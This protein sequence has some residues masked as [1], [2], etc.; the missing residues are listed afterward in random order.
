VNAQPPAQSTT[1]QH[2]FVIVLENESYI[3]TF[4]DP[5]LAP[6]LAD[7]LP[8]MGALLRQYYGVGHN[9]LD[10]YIAMI[11]GQAP[12]PFTQADC[13][14]YK[15]F[16]LKQ[17]QLD[18]NG[19][20]VGVGCVYPR[21]V[22]TIADQLDA[23]EHSKDSGATDTSANSRRIVWK[24]YMQDLG[25][26]PRREG[27]AC[28]HPALDAPDNTMRGEPGDH[29][30]TK[31]NPFFYFHSI[32]DAPARCAAHVVNLRQ[33]VAD[34]ASASSTPAFSFITPNLCDD[35]H[36]PSCPG[37]A[38]TSG[39]LPRADRFLRQW[40]PIITASAAF[41]ENGLL[42]I[43][44]DESG[45]AD[46][47]GCCVEGP[48]SDVPPAG[49]GRVGA[50]VLSPFIAPGTVSDHPYNHYSLLRSFEDAFQLGRLG[51][52]AGPNVHSFGGD[53]FRE[54]SSPLAEPPEGTTFLA[55]QVDKQPAPYP[56]NRTPEYPDPL[57]DPQAE[58]VAQVVVDTTGRADM[59]TF[60]VIKSDDELLTQS[61]R[62][63]ISSWR[64]YPGE[65]SGHK[66]RT[67]IRLPFTFSMRWERP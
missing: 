22:E 49:G 51:Y 43:T 16:A 10:N 25:N 47:R 66:V 28:G 41:R 11:S 32:I 52:A 55:Y 58:V 56:H 59:K 35:G 19:Q 57:R 12:N 39:G 21:S 17:L 62:T 18:A 34:L 6:Y 27:I 26:D 8:K 64:F 7:T 48:T 53:V 15:E 23:R 14:T 30:A 29:Y 31:H 67:M 42:V 65:R 9:S 46:T 20:A 60:R 61:V 2:V 24:G 3:T 40:V 44:F 45:R 37:E 54:G 4:A 63:A 13:P 38:D 36:D 33:L 1:I 5:P 50:V